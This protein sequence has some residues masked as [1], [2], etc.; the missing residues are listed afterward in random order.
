MIYESP[1]YRRDYCS[2]RC[3]ALCSRH[4]VLSN[5]IRWST[6]RS[7]SISRGQNPDKFMRA[8]LFWRA[9]TYCNGNGRAYTP[10]DSLLIFVTNT[11]THHRFPAGLPSEPSVCECQSCVT[12][13]Q[14]TTRWRTLAARALVSSSSR[15]TH[16]PPEL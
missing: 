16:A 8:A 14:L 12:V 3:E 2:N 10:P 7:T 5:W 13:P 9:C 15:R 4:V 11:H 1:V 6:A